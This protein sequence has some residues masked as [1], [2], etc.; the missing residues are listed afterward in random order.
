MDISPA[1]AA[2]REFLAVVWDGPPPSDAALA[3]ALD[4]LVV[5]YHATPDAAPSDSDLEA[6]RQDGATLHKELSARFPDYGFY[7]IADPAGLPGAEPPMVG[8]AIDDLADL[9][10]DMREAVWLAD[11]VSLDE[12]HWSFRLLFFHWG[13]HARELSLYLHAR[14]W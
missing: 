8:D 7:P 13:R 2:A 4:R 5:T 3:A 10:L 11:H 9:T 6:P 14:Q 1:I 12:A